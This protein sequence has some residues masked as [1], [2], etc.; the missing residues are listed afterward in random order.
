MFHPVPL[1]IQTHH[2]AIV[3]CGLCTPQRRCTT[4]L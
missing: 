1:P 4:H 2:S 3:S